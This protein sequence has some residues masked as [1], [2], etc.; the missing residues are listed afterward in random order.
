MASTRM[1]GGTMRPAMMS[2]ASSVATELDVLGRYVE[3]V[4]MSVGV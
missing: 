3:G 1:G 2:F 4:F